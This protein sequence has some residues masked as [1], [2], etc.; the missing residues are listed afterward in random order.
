VEPR[1]EVHGPHTD[2]LLHFVL[3]TES[4]NGVRHHLFDQLD[5]VDQT[6]DSGAMQKS[7]DILDMSP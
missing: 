1:A 4:A 5:A 3:A 2:S 7:R 6:A